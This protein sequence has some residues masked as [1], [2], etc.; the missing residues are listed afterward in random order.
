[1]I[2]IYYARNKHNITLWY[3]VAFLNPGSV[4]VIPTP[5]E[6]GYYYG[7]DVHFEAIVSTWYVFKQWRKN[8]ISVGDVNGADFVMWDEN[9]ELVVDWDL[10]TY[11]ID[12]YTDPWSTDPMNPN[13][14]TYTV[15]SGEI[16]IHNPIA[17]FCN[18]F[19]W[20]TWG[21]TWDWILTPVTWLVIDS[22][23]WWDRK[24]YANWERK[25]YE[26]E[27]S[28]DPS[29]WW[30]VTWEG[31]YRC[32]G[33]I[34]LHATPNTWYHFVGWYDTWGNIVSSNSMCFFR[35]PVGS[36]W[37]WLTAKFERNQY[38]VTID[39]NGSWHF[40]WESAPS[41]RYY[42]GT[43]ITFIAS[44]SNGYKIQK[45]TKNRQNITTWANN[46]LYTWYILDV[47]VT[48]TGNYEVYFEPETYNIIYMDS[49]KVLT[50]L[51]PA[52]YTVENHVYS[53]DLPSITKDGYTFAWWFYEYPWQPEYQIQEI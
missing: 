40:W 18:D 20:W 39:K 19:L 35:G 13:P 11:N 8:G 31:T 9:V 6:S 3:A 46:E 45:W 16:E 29:S 52:T 23:K 47:T 26:V 50:W 33:E 44:P 10:I 49:G 32:M 15:L 17:E 22:S 4:T 30:T 43:P 53:G 25:S 27:L 36:L 48:E 7:E 14:Q 1:M 28:V 42:H 5:R 12:Y 51:S 37:T 34:E 24:Y 2:N 41:G 38:Y 21:T